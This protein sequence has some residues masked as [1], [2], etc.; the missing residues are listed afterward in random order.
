MTRGGVRCSAGRIGEGANLLLL[1]VCGRS[2]VILKVGYLRRRSR[3][4]VCWPSVTPDTGEFKVIDISSLLP[5]LWPCLLPL[6]PPLPHFFVLIKPRER[7][8]PVWPLQRSPC[9]RWILDGWCSWSEMTGG[10]SRGS[11]WS[12]R[13]SLQHETADISLLNDPPTPSLRVVETVPTTPNNWV[14]ICQL[15]ELKW[16]LW[17][18]VW[19]QHHACSLIGQILQRARTQSA[20][21]RVQFRFARLCVRAG[22]CACVWTLQLRGGR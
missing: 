21:C 17:A 8:R 18:G 19:H 14:N 16:W 10:K 1:G 22:A 13:S 4:R 7:R 5:P 12:F 6:L 2:L 20:V 3:T 9:C 11:P 15:L